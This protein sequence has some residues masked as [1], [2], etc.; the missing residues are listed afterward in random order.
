MTTL[1]LGTHCIKVPD[2]VHVADDVPHTRVSPVEGEHWQDIIT[3]H[4]PWTINLDW[5]DGD[6]WITLDTFKE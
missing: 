5:E 3:F 4:K 2:Y 6:V 1:I